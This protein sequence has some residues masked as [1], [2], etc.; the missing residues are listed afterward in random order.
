VAVL[1]Y[2]ATKFAPYKLVDLNSRRERERLSPSGLKAFF[3]IMEHW[4]VRDESARALLGGVTNGPF[5]EMK[6]NSARVLDP[7]KLTRISYLI[8]IYKALNILYGKK[9]A[10]DWISLPN[11]NAIFGGNSALEYMISGGIPAMQTVRRLL[12]FRRGT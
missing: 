8:G 5:Y 4:Q 9:L 1:A 7:D 6:K 2:P 11:D 3:K 10:N 12:D